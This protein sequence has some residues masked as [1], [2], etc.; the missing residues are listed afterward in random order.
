MAQLYHVLLDSL[1]VLF[2]LV[3]LISSLKSSSTISVY[4]NFYG[5]LLQS[6]A[7]AGNYILSFKS[8]FNYSYFQD[9]Y[10]LII[11]LDFHP[12]RLFR[13]PFTLFKSPADVNHETVVYHYPLVLLASVIR[14][15]CN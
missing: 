6:H 13:I 9:L 4:K 3:V 8:V 11:F 5:L 2:L 12:L 14:V 1:S 7:L 10:S 15:L